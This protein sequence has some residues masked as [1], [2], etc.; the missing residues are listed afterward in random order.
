MSSKTISRILLVLGVLVL[1]Y[2]LVANLLKAYQERTSVAQFES[3]ALSQ[4]EKAK[5]QDQIGSYN[6]EL[7][8]GQFNSQ[9]DIVTTKDGE[10][11]SH[12]DFFNTG[13]VLGTLVIPGIKEKLPIYFGSGENVLRSGVGLMENTSYPGSPSGHA[14]ITGHRGTYDATIFRNLDRLGVGDVFY[15]Q[16]KLTVLKYK[17]FGIQT[18]EPMDGRVLKLEP[19]RDLVTLLTC[20]PYIFNT[21]RLLVNAERANFEPGEL[22]ALLADDAKLVSVEETSAEIVA[23]QIEGTLKAPEKSFLAILADL[24]WEIK[25]IILVLALTTLG[26]IF[27]IVRVKNRRGEEN[28][29]S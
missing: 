8:S 29:H 14:V 18:V 28:A 22:E 15:I 1:S 20:T 6:K 12:Y 3:V 21:H 4:A 17:V 13:E 16:D 27:A 9:V 5:I 24:S 11:V 26:S 7:E 2:P 25:A 23:P 10:A 19:H